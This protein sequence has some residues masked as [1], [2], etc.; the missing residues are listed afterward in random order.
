M[1][2][3]SLTS[4]SV[5]KRVKIFSVL[6][7]TVLIALSACKVNSS[8]EFRSDG[9]IHS[10]MVFE[11]SND[12]MKQLKGNCDQLKRYLGP[13]GK[14]IVDATTTDITRPGGHLTCKLTSNTPFNNVKLVKNGNLYTAKLEKPL[15]TGGDDDEEVETTFKFVMP[16][17]IVHASQGGVIKDN[18]VIYKGIDSIENGFTIVAKDDASKATRKAEAKEG[19]RLD[20][21]EDDNPPVWVWILTGLASL[22]I[23]IGI[24][25]IVKKQRRTRRAG[26]NGNRGF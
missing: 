25:A 7:L 2:S 21:I 19:E 15:E 11:D 14:F 12:S 22:G 9:S 13:L 3:A 10:E 24:V 23:V 6:T 16:G 18:T 26:I 20:S 17:K 8:F 5:L 1:N 4:S